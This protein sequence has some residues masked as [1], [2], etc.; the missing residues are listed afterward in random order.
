MHLK[1][2]DI[3]FDTIDNGIMILDENYN[4]IY[5]N[6]WLEFKTKITKNDILNKNLFD[7]FPNIK[8]KNLKRKIKT[9][10]VLNS[11]SY[12]S[13][14]PH[15]FLIDI[16][17]HNITSKI[18]KSMQ[19]RV[20][21]VPY[22][23]EKKQ[24][25]LYI[26]DQT[27]QS[28]INYKL[29]EALK[30]LENYKN[31]LEARVEK[32]VLKSK[33]KDTML[34]EQSKLASMGE[35]IGAIAHQW[36][37]PL[38]TLSGNIQF[39]DDDFDDNM[40][41][42][43]YIEQFINKNM[44]LIKFMSNTIDDFRNFF[45]VDKEKN[46]FSI[47]DKVLK[48][49]NILKSSLKINNITISINSEDDFQF[50]GMPTEFQQ[51]ILNIIHNA[52]DALVES[53]VQNK[54]II[55]DIKSTGIITISDNANGIPKDIQHRVFEPYFTTKEEGKGTGIGLYMSKTIVEEHMYGT[56]SVASDEKGASFK[57]LL[58]PMVLNEFK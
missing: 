29:N 8:E 36:R 4:I 55:I 23:I 5:W 14:E 24:V 50:Y 1:N 7:N 46:V 19:Q 22:N 3:I 13:V 53:N 47:K 39:L 2:S 25:C 34:S 28:E 43:K 30:E 52:K 10:L 37:Q 18:Y 26:Y 38:N 20:T 35:M 40:I 56:L 15:K 41:D 51:V 57:I 27:V 21:I 44:E 32:E 54:Q 49:L 45:R 12:Y 42:E 9:T 11:S 16:K 17:L 58:T 48:T 31:Q 6:N 33:E